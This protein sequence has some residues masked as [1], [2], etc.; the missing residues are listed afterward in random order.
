MLRIDSGPAY[1]TVKYF[2]PGFD[3]SKFTGASS[4]R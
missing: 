4:G 1:Q 2:V 3:W